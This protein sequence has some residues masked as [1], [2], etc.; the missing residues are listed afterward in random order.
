MYPAQLGAVAALAGLSQAFLVPPEISTADT[1]II[2]TLPFESAVGIN[3]RVMEINCPGCPVL[4]NFEGQTHSVQAESILQLNFSLSHENGADQLLLNG[5]QI[6][7]IDPT[8]QSFMEPLTASQMIKTADDTWQYASNPKLGYSLA[9]KR[10]ATSP[11]D[12]M[13]LVSIHLEIV[14]VADKFITGLP[15]I[16]LQLLETTSGK[17]MIGNSGITAPASLSNPTDDDR[18]C[19]TLLCKWRAI[20]ADRLAAL[21]KGCG[22]KRPT[23]EV[24][25]VFVPRPHHNKHPHNKHPAHGRPRPHG[26]HRP[27]RHHHR[28]GGLARLLRSIVLHVLVP[29]LIGVMVGITASLVGMV[30]GHIVVFAWRMLFRRGQNKYAQVKQEEADEETEDESKGFLENQGPPPQYEDALDVKKEIE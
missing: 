17:L 7:P 22:S 30:V 16:D 1:D 13:D 28:Q 6:Y 14:E 2:K 23:P 18:E 9:I 15:T 21:K 10:P 12:Q 11:Q 25:P 29:V 20:V 27:W 19:T 4:T 5:L 3:G 24:R 26:T 8:S